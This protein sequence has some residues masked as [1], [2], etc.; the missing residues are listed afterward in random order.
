MDDFKL[1]N[2]RRSHPGVTPPALHRLEANE[3]VELFRKLKQ[4]FDVE[5]DEKLAVL[6]E[7]LEGASPIDGGEPGEDAFDMQAVLA[8]ASVAP[9]ATLFINWDR[10]ETVDRVSAA[11]LT[12]YFTDIWY[13][14]ADDIEVFDQ[15][16]NWV[17][18]VP[19]SGPALLTRAHR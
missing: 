19:H 16:C 14:G 5:A 3:A 18:F 1:L 13:P 11:D 9:D 6:E 8:L 10:F 7:L 15:T 4:R 12:R 2:F 17:L